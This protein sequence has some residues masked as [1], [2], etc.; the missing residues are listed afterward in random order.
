MAT[1]EK[2]LFMQTTLIKAM[3]IKN[4]FLIHKKETHIL[5]YFTLQRFL[6]V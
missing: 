1:L 5:L 3:N 2:S 4:V 6:R